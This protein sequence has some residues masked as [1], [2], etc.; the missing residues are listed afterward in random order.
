MQDGS[1][2]D[3]R[4]TRVAEM[5]SERSP[6]LASMYRAALLALQAPAA[7]GGETARVSVVCHCMRELMNGLPTVMTDGAIPRPKP[8]SGSL[9]AKLPGLL[10]QHPGLDLEA[11]QD[12]IPL[13][14][15]V[16]EV[17]SNLISAV[18]SEQGRNRRNAAELVTGGSDTRHPAIH[19]WTKAQQFFLDWTHLDRNH[20]QDR[21][22]P[23]DD[24]LLT[25]IRV[26]E[27]VIEVRSA[28]FFENLHLL[29][30][31]LAEANSVQSGG[32]A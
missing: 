19:H 21:E 25:N 30:D 7:P 22:L 16:A 8:S 29:Q 32:T 11:D 14:K 5:L 31:L 24:V 26:V 20:A 28:Q 1:G 13:P 4:Q 27:D 10:A 15:A 3:E 12:L 17:F 9:T 23:A 18:A 2:L 6:K